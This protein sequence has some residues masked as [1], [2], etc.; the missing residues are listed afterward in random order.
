M[1]TFFRKGTG[2]LALAAAVTLA[3]AGSASAAT[4]PLPFAAV[5]AGTAA[6]TSPYT[7]EFHGLGAASLLGAVTTLGEVQITGITN[8]V[9]VGG[10]AN[11]NVETLTAINGDQLVVTSNDVACPVASNRYHGTGAWTV[12]GGTGRYAGARG[13]GTF[14]GV[15][16]F[17]QGVFSITLSGSVTLAH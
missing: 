4:P 10:V 17:N 12:T 6:I 1:R 15:S 14:D 5:F 11:I 7:T 13:S 3:A 8:D 2:S 9:C 16:D